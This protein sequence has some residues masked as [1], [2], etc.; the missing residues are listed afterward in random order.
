MQLT[1][2]EE[3]ALLGHKKHNSL[4]SPKSQL[5]CSDILTTLARGLVLGGLDIIILT[6]EH[7]NG[8]LCKDRSELAG[9]WQT[10]A[11]QVDTSYR[12]SFM[13]CLL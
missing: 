8:L 11:D 5:Q 7:Y 1:T 6:I 13:L 2:S 4:L 3:N 10:S 12:P 9:F